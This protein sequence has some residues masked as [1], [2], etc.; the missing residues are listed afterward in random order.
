MKKKKKEGWVKNHCIAFIAQSLNLFFW[1][2]FVQKE[3]IYFFL[4]CV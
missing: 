4:S 3:F 1:C 2:V